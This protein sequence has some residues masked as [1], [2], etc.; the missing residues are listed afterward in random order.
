MGI[1]NRHFDRPG[2]GI[3]KDAPRKKGLPRFIELIGRDGGSFFKA[4]VICAAGALPATLGVSMG[5]ILHNVIITIL[6]GVVGGLILAPFF[7][8]MY[9]TVLRAVRDEPGY[10]WHNYKRAMANN[11]KQS[12]LPGA[13]TG[14]MIAGQLLCIWIVLESQMK[15]TLMMAVLFCFDVLVTGMITPFL[16]SQL[17]LMDLPFA[18]LLK[19]SFLFA[20]GSAPR[21]LLMALVQALF[22]GAILLLMPLSSMLVLLFGF[23]FITIITMMIAFPVLDKVLNIEEQLNARR[24]AELADSLE[25]DDAE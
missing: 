22:W 6:S 7:A 11:W 3:S 20:F 12:L 2:P 5:L 19:N 13:L 10:W 16:W 18:S 25:Q 14:L 17:V 21:A 24:A 9:D 4:N 15:I 23:A 8:G 1:F